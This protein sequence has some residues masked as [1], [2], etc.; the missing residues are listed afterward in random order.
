MLKMLRE[1]AMWGLHAG[2]RPQNMS[3]L[4]FVS[5]KWY[6]PVVNRRAQRHC[7]GLL[8]SA[9]TTPSGLPAQVKPFAHVPRRYICFEASLERA[10]YHLYT[11]LLFLVWSA[12]LCFPPVNVLGAFPLFIG[13]RDKSEARR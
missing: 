4:Q 8:R 10:I 2:V 5:Q 11:S 9:W 3:L 12:A 1:S 13:R 6:V 7:Q